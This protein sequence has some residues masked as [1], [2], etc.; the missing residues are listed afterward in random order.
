MKVGSLV[1]CIK[2][3]SPSDRLKKM[4]CK[5]IYKG[6]TYTIR[7]I[8]HNLIDQKQVLVTLVEVI[9]PQNLI[10]CL[11]TGYKIEHFWELLPPIDNVEQWV[12]ENVE[13]LQNA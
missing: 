5:P 13:E 11:E 3:V 2:D 7:D 1:E 8:F 9:N 10:V 12:N 6:L 4:G